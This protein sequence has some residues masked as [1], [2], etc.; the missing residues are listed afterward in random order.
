MQWVII[1]AVSRIMI[2]NEAKS[3]EILSPLSSMIISVSLWDELKRG[4][5]KRGGRTMDDLNQDSSFMEVKSINALL[6]GLN[7]MADLP[8]HF[9]VSQKI[10]IL[11]DSTPPRCVFHFS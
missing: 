3:T 10:Y 2:Q 1:W 5:R 7:Q 6:Q 8:P 9:T 4:E 11:L